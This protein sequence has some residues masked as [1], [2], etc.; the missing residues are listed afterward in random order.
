[1]TYIMWWWYASVVR[2]HTDFLSTLYIVARRV[3]GTK[4][5]LFARP[6]TK[7]GE[8]ARAKG[9]RS[10]SNFRISAFCFGGVES[11]TLLLQIIHIILTSLCNIS[12]VEL[13]WYTLLYMNMRSWS[14]G[15]NFCVFAHHHVAQN[16][17]RT[18]THTVHR[19]ACCRS[20]GRSG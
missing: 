18:H 9:D 17:A 13:C 16:S 7:L 14:V 6:A 19:F 1:M 8:E 3:G 5:Q 20:I 4:G 10:S 15:R 11:D 2:P 12:R